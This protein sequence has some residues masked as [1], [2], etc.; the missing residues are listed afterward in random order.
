M[1]PYILRMANLDMRLKRTIAEI[2]FNQD[3]LSHSKNNLSGL[4]DF[5]LF[6]LIVRAARLMALHKGGHCLDGIFIAT[7]GHLFI[8]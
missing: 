3:L 2:I 4:M 1:L 8:R 6:V 7:I 5:H